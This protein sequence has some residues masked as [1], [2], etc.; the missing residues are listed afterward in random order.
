MNITLTGSL[1][2]IGR[3]LAETLIRAGHQ[4]NIISSKPANEAAIRALGATPSIGSVDDPAFLTKAFTG[5]DAVYTM[6]PPNFGAAHYRTY[7]AGIARQYATAIKAAAVPRVVNLSSIGAHLPEGTGP[8]AG[9]YDA[10]QILNGLDNVAITH[11]R[12]AFF[13]TNFYNDAGMIR[14]MG[15][16]GSNYGE[17]ETLVMVH[18]DDI[19][20]AAAEE[21]QQPGAGPTVRY[22]VSDRRTAGEIASVLGAAIGKPGLK[23]VEFTDAQLLE[24]MLKAGLPGEIAANFVELYGAVRGRKL[25]GD[26]YAH[27]P[28]VT[29][30]K[31]L[32]DFAREFAEKF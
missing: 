17:Q 12:P 11:L 16:L 13:Y 30:K 7:I 10:E 19:A 29:G 27:T 23:W 14:E 15:I 1:G 31:K 2:H 24:G 18:P 8:V 6:V 28:A 4:V 20:V 9:L 32:E 5:A 25:F 26:Y 22:V 21:L 3:P